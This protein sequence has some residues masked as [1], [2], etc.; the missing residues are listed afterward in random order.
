MCRRSESLKVFHAVRRAADQEDEFP[1]QNMA[2]R[3]APV[4]AP[5]RFHGDAGAGTIR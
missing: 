1:A 5:V 3:G 4:R 2:A